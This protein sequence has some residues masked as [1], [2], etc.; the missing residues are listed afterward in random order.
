LKTEIYKSIAVLFKKN[1]KAGRGRKTLFARQPGEK[2]ENLLPGA[3]AILRVRRSLEKR[4]ELTPS[5]GHKDKREIYHKER[6][7]WERMTTNGGRPD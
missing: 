4:M 6:K 1:I 2:T 5:G 3:T 7:R